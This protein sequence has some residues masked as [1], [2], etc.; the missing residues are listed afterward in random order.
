MNRSGW[1]STA[2][3]ALVA[4]FLGKSLGPAPIAYPDPDEART[5]EEMES[6]VSRALAESRAFVRASALIRLFEGLTKE[7]VSGAAHAVESRANEND[8]VDLQ[9]FLTAWA[10]LDPEAAMREVQ[11]SPIQS[12]RDLGLRVVMRE[13][14]AS[15]KTL[16]AG[17]YFDTLTDPEQRRIVAGPLVR[18]W[19]LSG[20][21]PGAL[22]LAH[23]L[24]EIEP[25]WDVIDGLVRGVLHAQGPAAALQMARTLDPRTDPKTDPQ[26]GGEFARKVILTTLDLA[27]RDDPKAAV[28]VY[29]AFAAGAAAPPAWLTSSLGSLAAQIGRSDPQVAV[30]WLMSMSEG[31]ER[32]RALMEVMSTWADRDFEPARAWFEKRNP[33]VLDATS[34]LSPPESALL[35]GLLR[36]M[37]RIRPAEAAPLS[38]RLRPES[39]RIETFRRVA[40]YWSATDPGAPTN[41]S[42]AW[43]SAR[44]SSSACA[45]RPTGGGPVRMDLHL[46]NIRRPTA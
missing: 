17:T 8:P 12:R 37:A 16:A 36:R 19:A 14:A 33:S 18:G 9:M 4:F 23:R 32:D 25:R 22:A 40:Y 46:K 2:A 29:D 11:R 3:A 45:K 41:G 10:H 31:P 30:E 20:D 26:K 1:V 7:N 6:E 28:G 42:R 5:A 21:M 39:N 43:I 35:A 38:V 13:W 27:G 34:K 24:F 15:G 44:R